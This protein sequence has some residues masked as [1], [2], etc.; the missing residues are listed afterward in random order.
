MYLY[1]IEGQEIIRSMSNDRIGM[2]VKLMIAAIVHRNA[3]ELSWSTQLF[4]M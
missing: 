4:L 3:P 1:R 2:I